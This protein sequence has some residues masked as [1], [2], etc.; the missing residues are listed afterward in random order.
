MVTGFRAV[1]LY[2]T[3]SME[4]NSIPAIPLRTTGSTAR[5]RTFRS[6]L[7]NSQGGSISRSQ[8][9]SPAARS[10][11]LY[12]ICVPNSLQILKRPPT[13]LARS[14]MPFKPQCPGASLIIEN[15]RVDTLAVIAN[16]ETQMK[17]P[18]QTLQDC[19]AGCKCS[20]WGQ[21]SHMESPEPRLEN[22]L[23]VSFVPF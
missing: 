8:L 20:K 19:G 15:L 21:H 6:L 17:A 9:G 13:S 16:S 7:N 14:R 5:S 18:I 23:L 4:S 12:S 1:C 3:S 11:M 10:G 22:A 2:E